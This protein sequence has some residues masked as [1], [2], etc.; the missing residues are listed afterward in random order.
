MFNKFSWKLWAWLRRT[1]NSNRAIAAFDPPPKILPGA[2][3]LY[4]EHVA[5]RE[6]QICR[7]CGQEL[8]TDES[9]A[10]EEN[11]RTIENRL[12]VANRLNPH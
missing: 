7:F 12:R 4:V 11:S 2:A 1:P 8:K 5:G 9:K 6:F 3:N 10:R